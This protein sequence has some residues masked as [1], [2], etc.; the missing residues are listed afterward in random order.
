MATAHNRSATKRNETRSF[1]RFVCSAVSRSNEICLVRSRSFRV[2]ERE[3][4][5]TRGKGRSTLRFRVRGK[6]DGKVKKGS[7]DKGVARGAALDAAHDTSLLSV[8]ARHSKLPPRVLISFH[9]TAVILRNNPSFLCTLVLQ[10]RAIRLHLSFSGGESFSHR[11]EVFCLF[12]AA[13]SQ[14]KSDGD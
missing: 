3:A 9:Q 8:S 2:P 4:A 6:Q 13:V 14:I 1:N 11:E 5:K 10:L 12:R 7:N